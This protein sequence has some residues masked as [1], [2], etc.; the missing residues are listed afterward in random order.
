MIFLL[1]YVDV[2]FLRTIT[3]LVLTGEAGYWC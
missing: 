2:F 3:A 1:P